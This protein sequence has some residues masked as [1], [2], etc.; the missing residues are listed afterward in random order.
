[1]VTVSKIVATVMKASQKISQQS[2]EDR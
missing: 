1:M 2:R